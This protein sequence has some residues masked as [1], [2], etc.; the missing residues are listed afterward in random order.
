MFLHQRVL[1]L[2]K[3]ELEAYVRKGRL[4]R[5]FG[6]DEGE[7]SYDTP[8][9]NLNLILKERMQLLSYISFA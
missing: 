3:E 2:I 1:A 8:K 9:K 6:N 5:H 7:F 4:M